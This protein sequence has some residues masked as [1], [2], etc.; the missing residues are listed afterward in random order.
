MADN[1]ERAEIRAA[2]ASLK[3]TDATQP[4]GRLKPVFPALLTGNAREEEYITRM[5]HRDREL[6]WD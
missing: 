6:S 1:F 2:L 5:V 4:S 3:M